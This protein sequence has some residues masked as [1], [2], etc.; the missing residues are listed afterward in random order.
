MKKISNFCLRQQNFVENAFL[1]KKCWRQH[2]SKKFWFLKINI[3]ILYRCLKF[4]HCRYCESLVIQDTLFDD[5][6]ETSFLTSLNGF[7]PIV[8]VHMNELIQH[9]EQ[10]IPTYNTLL[11]SHKR[12]SERGW[13]RCAFFTENLLHAV[14]CLSRQEKVKP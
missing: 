2:F 5:V 6:L 10:F 13:N 11:L 1:A 7:C 3:Y 12:N 8:H 4:Y 9:S 14:N